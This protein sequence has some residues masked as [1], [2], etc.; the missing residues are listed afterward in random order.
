MA[1]ESVIHARKNRLA[2][3]PGIVL[4]GVCC[5]MLLKRSHPCEGLGSDSKELTLS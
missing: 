5:E 4:Y 2:D 3:D 1:C